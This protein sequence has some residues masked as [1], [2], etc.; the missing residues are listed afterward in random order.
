MESHLFTPLRVGNITL[1]HR[2]IMAP[3]TRFRANDRG[4]HEQIAE[5]YY[6]QRATP[7]GLII[8]EATYTSEEAGGQP[9]APGLWSAQQIR[10]W[11]RITDKVHAKGGFIFAQLREDGRAANPD[12][13]RSLGHH[14]VAPSAVPLPGGEVPQPLTKDAIKRFVR[15][16]ADAGRDAVHGAGFDGV[17]I[18]NANGYLPDQFL[19]KRANLRNDEYGGNL[20]NRCRFTL[21][22]L[23]ALVEVVGQER[24]GIR[25]SPYNGF[26][27]M[28]K[29]DDEVNETFSY[30]V[31]EIRDRYPNLAYIHIVE[32]RITGDSDKDGLVKQS[33][34]YLRDIWNEKGERP[35]IAAGGFTKGDAEE[36]VRKL[37]GGVAFGRYFVSNPDLV[38]RLKHGLPLNK[39][40]RSTFYGPPGPTSTKGYTDYPFASLW[41]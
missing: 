2:V 1:S 34:K 3:L 29:P 39:Y 6:E 15:M 38:H 27:D 10:S 17:E 23:A 5:K 36:S 7:G 24:A 30:L 4:E 9:N 16:F 26:Q 33:S 21:E 8:G 12:H 41:N 22:A 25:F 32:P 19:D 40:D 37:G 31:R 20:E 14:Y 11:K 18:H 35:Y 13:I 28:T